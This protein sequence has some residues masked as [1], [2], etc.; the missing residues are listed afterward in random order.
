MLEQAA[1][2]S[3]QVRGKAV[4]DQLTH[5]VFLFSSLLTSSPWLLSPGGSLW[6][7]LLTKQSILSS[8]GSLFSSMQDT[9]SIRQRRIVRRQRLCDISSACFSIASS[10]SGFT[11]S[12]RTS[13]ICLRSCYRAIMP[14]SF[15]H[16][17]RGYRFLYW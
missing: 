12:W 6:T 3:E 11:L 4:S 1:L 17:P 7:R 15:Q 5:A 8:E 16:G 9:V 2:A 13:R 10:R 14:P